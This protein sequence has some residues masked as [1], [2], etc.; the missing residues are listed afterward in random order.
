MSIIPLDYFQIKNFHLIE[1]S[2]ILINF[3]IQLRITFTKRMSQQIQTNILLGL[4]TLAIVSFVNGLDVKTILQQTLQ[5]PATNLVATT[6]VV[7]FPPGDEGS[8]PHHHSG[9]VVGYVLKGS[10]LFQVCETCGFFVLLPLPH[11][12]IQ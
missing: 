9:P 11:Q 6:V 1:A 8:T 12:M 4:M 3:F 5:V 2:E 7:T 10:F